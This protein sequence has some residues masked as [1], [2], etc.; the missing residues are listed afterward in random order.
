M[1]SY[2]KLILP[3][4]ENWQKLNDR[5]LKFDNEFDYGPSTSD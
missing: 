2:D 4:F 1:A 5:L 3:V